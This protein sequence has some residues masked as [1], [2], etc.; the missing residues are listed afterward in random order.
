MEKLTPRKKAVLDVL[1]EEIA[2]LEEK[3]A[4]AQPMIDELQTLRATRARLLDERSP[5]AGGGRRNS[6]LTME[7]VVHFL[8]EEGASSVS[9]IA[10][11]A[12]VADHIVRAHLNRHSGSRYRKDVDGDWEL[13]GEDDGE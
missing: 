1:D 11:H 8:R 9:D 5:T 7:T 10:K 12:G 4:K 2:G 13:I 3:L 6:Q